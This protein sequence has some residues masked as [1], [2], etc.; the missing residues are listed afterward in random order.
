MTTFNKLPQDNNIQELIKSTFDTDLSLAG[1]WGYIQE[2]AT[3]IEALP[4][5]MSLNQ[6]EHMIT[7]IRAHIEMNLTQTNEN[8]YAG[9]NV[10]EKNREII[11]TEK[12]TFDKVSYQITA[13]KE[14]IY[15]TF[16]QEYKKGYGKEDFDLNLH[17]KK[18]EEATLIREI[19]HYFEISQL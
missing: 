9:I 10:N 5:G 12:G 17:F 3:I 7:S 16:I 6:L 18:R 14:T 13:M 15:T 8:R 1:N 2:D 11:Q 4:K 19:I